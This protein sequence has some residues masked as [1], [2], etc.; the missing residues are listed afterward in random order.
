MHTFGKA[1]GWEFK[2][3]AKA[4]AESTLHET[5][6]RTRDPKRVMPPPAEGLGERVSRNHVL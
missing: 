5:L 2:T 3:F 4:V 6:W 1:K